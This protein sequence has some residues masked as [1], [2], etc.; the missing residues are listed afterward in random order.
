MAPLTYADAGVDLSKWHDAKRRIG[1]LVK[2]THDSR[3]LGGF[4]HFG[5]LFD[6]AALKGMQ[7]PVLVSSVDGV[8]TKLKIAFEVGR[9]DT[10]GEDIV[11][12][13]IGDILVLGARP[14]FFLDYLATGK[15]AP[16]VV[17]SVIEGLA[18]ACKAAGCALIGGETAEMPG[19]YAEGEYDLAGSI[20]GVVDRGRIVDGHTIVAGDM[21]V[22]LRS[23]GLHTNGYSLA[24]KIVTEVAGKRYSDTFEETGKT[25]GEELL[26]P[27]RAYSPVL[28]L[29]DDGLVKGCA[30]ITGGG[31]QENI[32]R[33]LPSG[34]DAVVDTR[35]WQPQPIMRFLQQ[36]GEVSNDDMYRTFNM[37]IG[38]VLAVAAA[39]A[40]TVLSRSELAAFEPVVIGRVDDGSGAVKMEY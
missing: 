21:L 29:M 7:D 33:I 24:R 31:F 38:M 34:C 9:H 36:T 13:C 6:A 30:H 8:G 5:G 17:E 16:K 14:L 25:F 15:L 35:S 1:A 19:F 23:S 28:G 32:D 10:V 37:G 3:V 12:H 2:A 11:N 39:D 40:D 22:G 20:V 4:G 18:R 26:C 27:H